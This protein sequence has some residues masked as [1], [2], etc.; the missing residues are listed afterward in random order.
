MCVCVCVRRGFSITFG[1]ITSGSPVADFVR[2]PGSCFLLPRRQK[3]KIF[4]GFP[5]SH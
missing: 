5:R 4:V 1:I 3:Q 2:S